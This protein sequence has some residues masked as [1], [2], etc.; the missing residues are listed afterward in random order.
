MSLFIF[1]QGRDGKSR[2]IALVHPLA[3]GALALG[4]VAILGAVFALG[5]QLGRHDGRVVG[6]NQIR[7]WS[8]VLAH[9]KSEL[10]ALRQQVQERTDTLGIR[11]ARLDAHIIRI[12]ELGK[13]LVQMAHINPH[14]FNFEEDPPV[15]G[16]PGNDNGSAPQI[17]TLATEL[18]G[19]E[20]RI[21][22][23]D[24]QLSA[25][26]NVILTRKLDAEIHPQ[27]R[28]VLAGFI[29]SFFGE[30]TDPF[31]GREEFHEGIDFAGA[32][33]T[34]VLAVAAGVVTWAAPRDGF[35]NLVEISH[36]NGY[37]TLYAHNE[38][39]LV[40]VGQTVARGQTIA[41]MGSTGR[42]TGPHVHFE[43]LHF[44]HPVNPITFVRR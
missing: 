10:G 19:L 25:L 12:D 8:S 34:P 11:M 16:P 22:L 40:K 18:R 24:A 23:R 38:R 9:Q 21:D 17:P 14:E 29:S 44:G 3:R 39:L 35:G 31:T 2:Q 7:H 42:S 28:P 13:R 6:Q 5:V 33:G 20:Q 27:G 26:Q 4:I 41:L 37:A 32:A 1:S 36:G 15:G 30:R 43:V